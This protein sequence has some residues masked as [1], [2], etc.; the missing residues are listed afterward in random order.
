[1]PPKC[2]KPP[3]RVWSKESS[4]KMKERLHQMVELYPLE[5]S[6][7]DCRTPK[8][9]LYL[10]HLRAWMLLEN[11]GLRLSE[12]WSLPLENIDVS[13]AEIRISDI[14]A[15]GGRNNRGKK[16]KIRFRV[17]GRYGQGRIAYMSQDVVGFLEK[18]KALRGPRERWFLDRGDG[19]NLYANPNALGRALERHQEACGIKGEAKRTH[20]YRATVLTELCRINPYSAQQQAGHADISTTIEAY[21]AKTPENVKEA[22]NLIK[23]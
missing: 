21:A 12:V 6:Q 1:M 16:F 10:N 9:R 20:S 23:K 8:G 14:D 2:L 19:S 11:C 15:D 18:D 17:K 3:V 5:K 22:L 13:N 4:K 7:S